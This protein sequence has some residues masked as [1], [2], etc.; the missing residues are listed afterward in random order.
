[1]NELFRQTEPSLDSVSKIGTGKLN[2]STRN[3]TSEVQS[4]RRK[5]RK[6][7]LEPVYRCARHT[8]LED[9]VVRLGGKEKE[10]VKRK[11]KKL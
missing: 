1:M 9:V 3:G 8:A 6:K 5:E 2:W 7:A 10:G 11:G 4:W